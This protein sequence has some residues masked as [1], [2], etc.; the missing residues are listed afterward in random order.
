M[1]VRAR[2]MV[3]WF[4]AGLAL[5]CFVPLSLSAR[6]SEPGGQGGGLGS[7]A[8]LGAVAGHSAATASVFLPPGVSTAQIKRLPVAPGAAV[9]V[10]VSGELMQIQASTG[11]KYCYD[12]FYYNICGTTRGNG[13]FN[14]IWFGPP[15]WTGDIAHT[16]PL[17]TLRVPAGMPYPAFNPSHVYHF[18]LNLT[19]QQLLWAY[20][21]GAAAKDTWSGG[22]T[23][24]FNGTPTSGGGG[25]VPVKVLPTPTMFGQ[26]VSG[27]VALGGA[28][29][30]SSPNVDTAGT[31]ASVVADVTGVSPIDTEMIAG[32]RNECYVNFTRKLLRAINVATPSYRA[33]IQEN[34]TGA[35][36]HARLGIPTGL[37]AFDE[38]GTCLAFVDAVEAALPGN[39][40][41]VNQR[42]VA[43]SSS[44]TSSPIHLALSGSGSTTRLRSFKIGGPSALRTSCT[45]S[46]GQVALSVATQSTGTPLRSV[47]GSNLAL[48]I[49]RS[50]NDTAGG[51]LSVVFNHGTP[52]AGPPDITGSWANKQAPT[53]GPPWQLTT[54]NGRQT[55]D[56]TWT[57]GP[58]HGGLRGSFHGSLTA[59]NAYTGTFRVTEASTVVTGTATFTIESASQIEIDLQPSGGGARQ[60]YTFVRTS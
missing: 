12:A 19:G 32:A 40:R 48:G 22:F 15:G 33:A 8:R 45:S 16:S 31:V 3:L 25:G 13:Q 5:L 7:G 28:V 58:G 44:C 60:Q 10:V 49:V 39:Q 56:A 17:S 27:V 35:L 51:Q 4:G 42:A 14:T 23:L 54:S 24:D 26:P 30:V 53:V 34:F 36:L 46:P 50:P 41:A 47:V 55:L 29:V 11:K 6:V 38:L 18:T 59:A 9:P 37:P 57:G 1:V 20:P 43:A 52:T 21:H 2:R